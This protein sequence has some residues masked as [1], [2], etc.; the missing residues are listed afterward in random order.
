MALLHYLKRKRHQRLQVS[1]WLI[2][3]TMGILVILEATNWHTIYVFF[4]IVAES[5]N[6]VSVF[7]S[8]EHKLHTTRSWDF[9]GLEKDGGIT[10]DSA[11]W[12]ARFGEDTI[13][14]NLDS[15]ICFMLL[16]HILE[17]VSLLLVQ[18]DSDQMLLEWICF[19]YVSL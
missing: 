18:W 16:C 9:L 4:L 15:G 2:N 17:I 13:M 8:K 12:K 11:W 14:A 3:Y 19:F 10:L 6:V 7:L 1:K 5:P